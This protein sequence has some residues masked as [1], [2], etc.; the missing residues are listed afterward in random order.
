[1]SEKTKDLPPNTPS[2]NG[3]PAGSG[4]QESSKPLGEQ[5]LRPVALG[6]DPP[7]G[8]ASPRPAWPIAVAAL[9]WVAWIAFLLK[10][11]V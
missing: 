9:G 3:E 7:V 11:T 10:M 1:M 2:A 5:P 4:D 6:T 8:T